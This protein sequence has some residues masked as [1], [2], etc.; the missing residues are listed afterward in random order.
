MLK[1]KTLDGHVETLLL[2]IL[3]QRPNYGYRIVRELNE[4]APDVLRM[5]EGTVY[6]VLHRM[7][8][9]GLLTS[10]WETADAG[11]PRKYYYVTRGGRRQFAA[12]QEQWDALQRLMQTV[13]A[14]GERCRVKPAGGGVM[15]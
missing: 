4:L 15:P 1:K 6:P 7:E 14:A 13:L 9:R 10:Q 8:Q 11:R 2:A 3:I 12:G 5:G